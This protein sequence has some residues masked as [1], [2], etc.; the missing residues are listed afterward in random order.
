MA[1]ILAIDYGEKRSGIAC[2]DPLQIIV[3]PVAGIDTADL[4]TILDDYLQRE[5]VEK[6]VFGM[7]YLADAKP[8][9]LAKLIKKFIK[10]LAKKYPDLTIDTEHEGFTTQRA[11]EVI[12]M[13]GVKKQKRKDKHLVDKMSAVIILQEYLGHI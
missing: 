12:Y 8:T 6:I 2:T 11:K 5:A 9:H 4:S 13:S 3:S 7:P 10:S 1:R